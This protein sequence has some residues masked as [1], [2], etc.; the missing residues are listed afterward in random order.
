MIIKLKRIYLEPIQEK[1]A[2]KMNGAINK[3]YFELKEWLYWLD[4]RP[5]KTD[6]LEF[7]KKTYQ[8]FLDKSSM[9]FAIINNENNDFIGCIGVNTFNYQNNSE[10]LEI[11]YWIN[12]QY[13]KKGYMLE[14]LL[15]LIEYIKRNIQYTNIVI[16][17]DTANISSNKLAINAGFSLFETKFNDIKK[18]NQEYRDTNVYIYKN[19]LGSLQIIV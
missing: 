5:T 8:D 1:H 18:P 7:C 13:T 4:K 17:T 14:A 19:K 16:T 6:S 10:H 2:I 12:T 11:G 3:S 9:Q 15:G